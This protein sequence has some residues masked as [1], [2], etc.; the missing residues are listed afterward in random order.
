MSCNKTMTRTIFQ[1]TTVS[2][3][4]TNDSY[5]ALGTRI[6]AAYYSHMQENKTED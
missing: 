5:S 4:T 3:Q 1:D 6:L 2:A